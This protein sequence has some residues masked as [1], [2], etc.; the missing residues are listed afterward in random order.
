MYSSPNIRVIKSKRLRWARHVARMM[1]RRGAYR[2][3]VGKPDG[4]R[5]FGRTKRRWE[6]NI[7]MDLQEVGI[8]LAQNR[9]RWL[10]F[11]NGIM[12]FVFH[13]LRDIS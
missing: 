2:G 12:S 11:V 5:P 3:L 6:N 10:T 9:D 8:N 1:E 4:K 13:K 7:N